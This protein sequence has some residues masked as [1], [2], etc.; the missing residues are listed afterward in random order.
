MKHTQGPWSLGQTIGL[1]QCVIDSKS[2]KI[3]KVFDERNAE[4]LAAAPE[5][6]AW[7]EELL[8]QLKQD[9]PDNMN[10]IKEHVSNLITR[11]KGE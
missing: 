2:N 8:K 6:L 11:A 1:R 10:G 5:L 9:H 7:C 4:L 3:C